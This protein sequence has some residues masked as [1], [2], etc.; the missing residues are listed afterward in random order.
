MIEK[1]FSVGNSN[2]IFHKFLVSTSCSSSRES[3]SAVPR[4]REAGRLAED[5]E[6]GA[7]QRE[8]CMAAVFSQP[9]VAITDYVVSPL[10]HSPCYCPFK[11]LL[12]IY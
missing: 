4:S 8:S 3:P 2:K 1:K 10:S 12:S 6:P 9:H 5:L 7:C 11:F